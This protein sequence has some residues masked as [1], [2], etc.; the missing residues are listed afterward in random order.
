MP[1]SGVWLCG[2]YLRGKFSL[3]P[4]VYEKFLPAAK[5][6]SSFFEAERIGAG[7]RPEIGLA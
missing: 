1:V 6:R 7:L 3:I 2:D 4:G 5:K